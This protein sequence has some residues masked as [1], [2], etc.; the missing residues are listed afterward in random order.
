MIWSW[1][2]TIVNLVADNPDWALG[3][4]FAAAII[5]AVALLGT[6]IPGTPLLMAVAAAAAAAGQPMVPFLIVAVI[7]AIIGDFVSFWAGFRF[8]NQL[9]QCWPLATRPHL[10]MQAEAFFRRYGTAS[11]AICRFIPVLRS[12][13]PLFAGMAGM[14]RRKFVVANI[15]SAFIWAPAHVYPAAIAGLSIESLQEGDWQTATLWGAVLLAI[16]TAT[17]VFHRK[18]AA[19][20]R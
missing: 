5:E 11:V 3:I 17:W 4:A 1:V 12:T 6:I 20:A 7:G 15:A 10:M 19:R 9:R 18:V 2:Q 14:E 13:V 16:A 8:S